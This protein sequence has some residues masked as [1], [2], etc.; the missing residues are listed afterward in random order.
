M[1]AEGFSPSYARE[2]AQSRRQKSSRRA[3]RN[4]YFLAVFSALAVFLYSVTVLCSLNTRIGNQL[5]ETEARLRA[6]EEKN[7]LLRAKMES[8][9]DCRR[10]EKFALSTGMI[11][12]LNANVAADPGN[13]TSDYVVA[14]FKPS[15]FVGAKAVVKANPR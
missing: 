9:R 5:A 11:M 4:P 10:V 6:V 1:L 3:T 15:G 7:A 13:T 12:R 8:L 2:Y 14:Q